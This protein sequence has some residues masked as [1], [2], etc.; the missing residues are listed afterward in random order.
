LK[1]KH[2]DV[3]ARLMCLVD[4]SYSGS[5]ATKVF[6]PKVHINGKNNIKMGKNV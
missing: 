1:V 5:K 6:I 3:V 2:R 4:A